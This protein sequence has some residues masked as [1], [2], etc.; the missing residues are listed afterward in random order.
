MNQKTRWTY[1]QAI[2]GQVNR[3]LSVAVSEL[4]EQLRLS[5]KKLKIDTAE[6]IESEEEDI[7]GVIAAL[8]ASIVSA[9]PAIALQIYRFNSAQFLKV[10]NNSGGK[11]NS[12]VIALGLYG[13]NADE[14]WWRDFRGWWILATRTSASKLLNNIKDSFIQLAVEGQSG[15]AIDLDS[16]YSSS[17]KKTANIASGIV[18]SLNSRLMKQRLDDAGVENYVWRGVLDER[19]RHSHVIREGVTFKVDGSDA[20]KLDG[21]AIFPGQQYGCRCWSVPKWSDG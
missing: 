20:G 5:A 2:E 4:T 1:P 7:D 16:L 12:A 3:N 8:L 10:A 18:S 13:V 17:R 15:Q 11:N 9:L 14:L 6:E 21:L 19:E